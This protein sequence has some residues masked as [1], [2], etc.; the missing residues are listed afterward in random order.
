M[1]EP[2]TPDVAK[3]I[4]MFLR[5]ECVSPRRT[6]EEKAVALAALGSYLSFPEAVAFLKQESLS[7]N[8]SKEEKI[9]ALRALGGGV[10]TTSSQLERSPGPS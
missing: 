2:K 7:V 1:A 4:M 8:R 3:D 10:S 6:N 5:Q 9:A